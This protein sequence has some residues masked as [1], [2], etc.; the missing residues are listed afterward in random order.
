MEMPHPTDG[1]WASLRTGE[2]RYRIGV[3]D[4]PNMSNLHNRD[5]S[6]YH[7]WSIKELQD[8]VREFG[9]SIGVDVV[10]IVSN[11]E[12]EI[13]EWIHREAEN[14]DGF[15]INPAGLTFTGEPTKWALADSNKPFI[16]VHYRNVV[17]GLAMAPNGQDRRFVFTTA[18]KG[19]TFGF[20]QYSYLTAML[21]LVWTLDDPL[22]SPNPSIG[23]IC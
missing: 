10:S 11:H 16:E 12:G 23:Q 18:A 1:R 3:I 9:E 17:L 22:I 5:K 19:M 2:Q 21:G 6:V 7:G 20:Q 13:V 14:V 8:F 15:L 4:G